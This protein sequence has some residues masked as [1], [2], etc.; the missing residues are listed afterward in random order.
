[1]ART[2]T[3][4]AANLANEV[5]VFRGANAGRAP[6]L[7]AVK[8]GTVKAAADAVIASGVAGAFDVVVDATLAASGWEGR[9]RVVPRTPEQLLNDVKAVNTNRFQTTSVGAGSAHPYGGQ[10]Q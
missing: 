7:I 8:D 6:G 5:T 2:D 1:M 9:A 3:L 10:L 4:N